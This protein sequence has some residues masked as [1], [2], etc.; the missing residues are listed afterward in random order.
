MNNIFKFFNDS[1]NTMSAF[2]DRV[3]KK[4]LIAKKY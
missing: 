1:I 3:F 4:D 2:L